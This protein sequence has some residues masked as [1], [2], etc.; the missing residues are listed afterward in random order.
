LTALIQEGLRLVISDK[1]ANRRSQRVMP[2]VSMAV[3]GLRPKI[4]VSVSSALQE[5]EDRENLDRLKR[6]R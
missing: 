3:G 1:P 6:L 4:D 5:T 2:R